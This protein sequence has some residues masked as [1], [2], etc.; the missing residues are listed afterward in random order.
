MNDDPALLATTLRELIES[1]PAI[2]PDSE[3]I[4]LR[5]S[6]NDLSRD[7]RLVRLYPIHLPFLY[8]AIP[9]SSPSGPVR[10]SGICT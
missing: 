10:L 1:A 7:A 2:F 8:G 4:L 9:G 3:D 5:K 6:E